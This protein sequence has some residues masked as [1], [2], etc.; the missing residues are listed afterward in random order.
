VE[1]SKAAPRAFE[2]FGLSGGGEVTLKEGRLVGAEAAT[3]EEMEAIRI[4]LMKADEFSQKEAA[5]SRGT[6]EAIVF[7][8]N[9]R[10]AETLFGGTLAGSENF[11][12]FSEWLANTD[13]GKSSA[14]RGARER[15]GRYGLTEL[16]AWSSL[17]QYGK[18]G[19]I[20]LQAEGADI[21][22]ILASMFGAKGTSIAAGILNRAQAGEEGAL[23]EKD[24]GE[25][26][27]AGPRG[28]ARFGKVM[29]LFNRAGVSSEFLQRTLQLTDSTKTLPLPGTN[30]DVPM[31][32]APSVGGQKVSWS[33]A[34][35][36]AV[37]DVV[38]RVKSI[39]KS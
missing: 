10:V 37:E 32:V 8:R 6:R 26:L 17:Y 4:R 5:A 3:K 20:S 19:A 11:K 31:F 15:M 1:E 29:E 16:S 30:P 24:I 28:D 38:G 13:V 39:T 23:S 12:E 27:S 18:E 35:L 21:S 2:P 33:A 22:K 36:G 7:S 25:I 34:L 14:H 9:R